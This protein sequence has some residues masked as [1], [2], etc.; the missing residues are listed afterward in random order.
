MAIPVEETQV[1]NKYMKRCL[2]S[3]VFREIEYKM[4]NVKYNNI[5]HV[6]K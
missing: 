1:A 2:F 3:A 5:Q 4:N 6:S